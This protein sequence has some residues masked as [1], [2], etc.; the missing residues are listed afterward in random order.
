MVEWPKL[1]LDK[2]VFHIT[3]ITYLI[4][5]LTLHLI[6]KVFKSKSNEAFAMFM[7]FLDP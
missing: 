1:Y 7:P 2:C 4:T 5:C 3:Y 6:N